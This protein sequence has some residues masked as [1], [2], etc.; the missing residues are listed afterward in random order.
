[1]MINELVHEL[2]H[3]YIM[4]IFYQD[5]ELNQNGELYIA[6]NPK[7]KLRVVDGSCLAVAVVVKSIPQGTKQVIMTGKLSKVGFA[8]AKTL[9]SQREIQVNDIL[10][11]IIN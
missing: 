2:I 11:S 10:L 1:M 6:K 9:L 8:V 5:E 3:S 4:S 7:L